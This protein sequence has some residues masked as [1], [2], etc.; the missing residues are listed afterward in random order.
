MIGQTV[1]HYRIVEKLGG[2]GM[3]VVYKAEDIR[4]GRF[5]AL[6]F[7]PTEVARDPQ[8]LSRFQREAQAASS[9]NHANICT[10]YD[11]GE[12][13]G[14]AFIAMELLEGVTLTHL[15]GGR[16][17]ELEPL[18]RIAIDV[19]EGL[20][21]AHSKGI[22]HR[23]IKPAN[24]IVHKR[25]H[26]KILDFGLAKLGGQD[27][28]DGDAETLTEARKLLTDP[29]TM[30]G[31]VAY[32][33]PE[34]VRAE[35]LD[36]RTDLFSLGVVLYEMA[37][38]TRP[39]DGKTSGEISGAVLYKN[40]LPAAQLNSR[41]PPQ[42]EAIIGRALEK[43]RDARYQKA[44]EISTALQQLRTGTE[45]GQARTASPRIV[46][47]EHRESEL[48]KRQLWKIVVPFVAVVLAAL[49]I[50]GLYRRFVQAARLSDKDTII[51]ADF[52]NTTGEA[53]FDD[54]LRQ[55]LSVQ[56]SQSPFLNL[57][58]DQRVN[59][60]LKL[61]GRTVGDRLTPDVTREICARTNTKAMLEGTISK[62]GLQYVIGLKAVACSSG[63]LLALDQVQAN[64]KEE[65]LP[66][67]EK[68]ATRIR[69]KL[70]ESMASVQRFDTPLAQATTSSLEAL[71]AY[72]EGQKVRTQKGDA[73]AIAFFKNAT[74]LDPAFAM[75][76]FAL[77]TSYSNIFEDGLGRENF[78][79]AYD[80]R[81]RVSDREKYSIS[82]GYYRSV[83]G[84]LEK[85]QK[86]YGQWA[87]AYPRDATPYQGMEEVHS[88][89]GQYE[90]SV[91]DLL[92]CKRLEPENTARY[93]NLV[94]V[95]ALLNRLAE[96]KGV[97]EELESHKAGNAASHANWYGVAFLQGDSTEMQRQVDWALAR[98]EAEDL[99]LA[100]ESDTKAFHG[101]MQ[102][103]REFSR[104]A[105][106]A[107]RQNDEK[108]SAAFW[109]LD[110]ALREAE[111]GDQEGSRELTESALAL[112][113][114]RD[115]KMLG[116]LALARAGEITRPEALANAVNNDSPLNTVLNL[117]W[118]PTIR[119]SIEINRRNYDK[120][121]ELLKPSLPYDFGSPN[122]G[123]QIGGPVY[124]PYVRGEAY[125]RAGRPQEALAEFQ[126]LLDRPYIVQNF[127][128]GSLAQLQAG[129]A[130]AASG[131][132]DGAREAYQKFLTLWKE[133][134]PGVPVLK[135]AKVEYGNLDQH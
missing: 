91:A 129:R 31:T 120:A 107:A 24:I 125:L 62:L 111:T 126:K 93:A 11:I 124:P 6:K 82:A 83:T 103:A 66:A 75:A 25:G 108:E 132:K 2:G 72:T 96:A 130:K 123:I 116:A 3:G 105:A 84:E 46:T 122:P 37:T 112:A 97:Y 38:G 67:L 45:S 34:Q 8:A 15:I 101:Q 56:L 95:Y 118:L 33:S 53:V 115:L 29:G 114:S 48:R 17:L 74:D 57:M 10:I 89:L 12:D 23:D 4:L 16:P 94:S 32:M 76:Y 100:A 14:R 119:A 131:D 109:M 127:V 26:A 73:A 36:G 79:K 98:P 60:T 64:S 128:L 134:D 55:G 71:K 30:L 92:E 27:S 61:M 81:D 121:I 99:L 78:Q 90:Q 35:N 51:L 68:S 110:A 50:A 63:E 65:V 40:P 47:E 9:L 41:V 88:S 102:K 70:G 106:E 49:A 54:A 5:V 39:F 19:A 52:A 1:S 80:L 69:S 58:P 104:R 135:D 20:D 7:L 85:A 13:E 113:S 133:A 22:V 21:A 18:L 86:V 28:A 44:S 43:D 77:G 59:E 117:Y 42:L 87:E